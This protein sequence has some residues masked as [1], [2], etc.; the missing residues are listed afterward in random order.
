MLA[1][2]LARSYQ[3]AQVGQARAGAVVGSQPRQPEPPVARATPAAHLEA[4]EPAYQVAQ[5]HRAPVA[6]AASGGSSSPSVYRPFVSTT[7]PVTAS[8]TSASPTSSAGCRP[9]S[10]A[11]MAGL[12]RGTPSAS[13]S[14]MSGATR[15]TLASSSA[16]PV[17][18]GVLRRGMWVRWR[19]FI[20]AGRWARH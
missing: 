13:S 15:A 18:T 17:K 1:Y 11:T 9:A 16:E 3:P 14:R 4:V 12:V 20:L 19:G 2:V 6:H 10:A 7:R 5:R 8:R